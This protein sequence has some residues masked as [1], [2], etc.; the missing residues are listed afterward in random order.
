MSRKVGAAWGQ[1]STWVL[2]GKFLSASCKVASKLP[3]YVQGSDLE[4]TCIEIN[5]Y[6]SPRSLIEVVQEPFLKSETPIHFHCFSGQRDLG[7]LEAT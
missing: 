1:G 2:L 5:G 6:K 7:R 3:H 4:T